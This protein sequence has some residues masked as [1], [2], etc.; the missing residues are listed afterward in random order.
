MATKRGTTVYAILHSF[1]A[2]AVSYIPV[3]SLWGKL[4]D[5]NVTSLHD[6]LLKSNAEST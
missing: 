5:K 4:C 3:G 2:Y 1:S 6:L